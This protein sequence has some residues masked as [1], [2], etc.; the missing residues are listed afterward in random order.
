MAPA[1]KTPSWVPTMLSDVLMLNPSHAPS[2][3]LSLQL[4]LCS[5]SQAV[6]AGLKNT[7]SHNPAMGSMQFLLLILS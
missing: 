2:T 4:S 5:F 3:N 1:L 6:L 7:I